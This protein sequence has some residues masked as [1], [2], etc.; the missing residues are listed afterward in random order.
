MR[1]AIA[2]M[3][4]VF[5]SVFTARRK[6]LVQ[7]IWQVCLEARLE[8]NRAHRGGASDVENMHYAGADA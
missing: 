1:M 7:L 4:G 3:P 8:F 5:V 2:I 6:E